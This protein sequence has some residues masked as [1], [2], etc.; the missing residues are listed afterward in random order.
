MVTGF[1]GLHDTCLGELIDLR[2]V[3]DM[4]ESLPSLSPCLFI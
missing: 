1:S 3:D 4:V 2:F